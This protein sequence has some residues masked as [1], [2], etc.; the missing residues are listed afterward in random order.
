MQTTQKTLI[1]LL[2]KD[3]TDDLRVRIL[4]FSRIEHYSIYNTVLYS[5]NNKKFSDIIEIEN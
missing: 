2:Y 1:L 4:Y 3:S 5:K